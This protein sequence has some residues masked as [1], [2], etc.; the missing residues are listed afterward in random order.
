MESPRRWAEVMAIQIRQNAE[1]K[2]WLEIS[3]KSDCES[4]AQIHR[5]LGAVLM[6]S[7]KAA[8]DELI[9]S[10]DKTIAMECSIPLRQ[11]PP[12]RYLGKESC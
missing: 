2:K 3:A 9:R 8:T 4:E 1:T 5:N 10:V 7:S 11:Q 6:N 12:S